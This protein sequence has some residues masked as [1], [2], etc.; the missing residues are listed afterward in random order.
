MAYPQG[1]PSSGVYDV[2]KDNS[3]TPNDVVKAI[4]D[5]H[6]PVNRTT[7]LVS[8][9]YQV[10]LIQNFVNARY[11]GRESL[12]VQEGYIT[13]GYFDNVL[14]L[15]GSLDSDYTY[16]NI[17][18][19]T[20]DVRKNQGG[21]C[22][23]TYLYPMEVNL[24]RYGSTSDAWSAYFN[25][26][27]INWAPSGV[28]SSLRIKAN[29]THN[30]IIAN[31][32]TQDDAVGY[33]GIMTVYGN[34]VSLQSVGSNINLVG[35][36][37]TRLNF[38]G[39][40]LL[41][42]GQ[43]TSSNIFVSNRLLPWQPVDEYDGTG[44]DLGSDSPLYRAWK[45]AYLQTTHTQATYGTTH[46]L[47]LGTKVFAGTFGGVCGASIDDSDYGLKVSSTYLCGNFQY[48]NAGVGPNKIYLRKWQTGEAAISGYFQL[49]NG[50]LEFY[51]INAGSGWVLTGF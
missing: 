16:V 1:T 18:K 41:V 14:C 40:T 37:V 23:Y 13:S 19:H 49:N 8:L 47:G 6:S 25:S 3:F 42:S 36:S 12:P 2:F 27:G 33:S 32:S 22:G 5:N 48:L 35:G 45:N 31:P 7:M 38:C 15:S 4:R 29:K 39:T 11:L 28:E 46:G 17:N 10:S 24:R 50:Q 9:G 34:E 43:S 20:V 26:S 44:Q 21:V 30:F 51:S